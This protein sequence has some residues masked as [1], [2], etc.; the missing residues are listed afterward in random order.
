M[1]H[2][3]V[4]DAVTP[5]DQRGCESPALGTIPSTFAPYFCVGSRKL[6]VMTIPT[7]GQYLIFWFNKNWNAEQENTRE[8]FHPL[9]R[10]IFS[11]IFFW[12]FATRV[13]DRADVGGVP[14]RFSPFLL[15]AAA[16][17]LPA[18]EA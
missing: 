15:A 8:L 17:L 11:P 18:P 3:A 16:L 2:P 4:Y 12:S 7:L 5:A 13:K 10:A 9:L 14:A 1:T 6:V